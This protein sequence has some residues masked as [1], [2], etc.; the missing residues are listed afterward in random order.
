ME[1]EGEWRKGGLKTVEL[2]REWEREEGGRE[3]EEGRERETESERDYFNIT[4]ML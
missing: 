2:Q 4:T 1:G 3:R